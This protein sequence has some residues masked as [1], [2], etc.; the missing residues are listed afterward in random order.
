MRLAL[1]PVKRREESTV[2]RSIKV[3]AQADKATTGALPHVLFL[4]AALIVSGCVGMMAE[5][6]LEK[7]K[8]L[9]DM[10][11]FSQKPAVYLRTSTGPV[12]YFD[13]LKRVTE[14][15]G[16]FRSF[17]FDVA[18]KPQADYTIDIYGQWKQPEMGFFSF[19]MVVGCVTPYGVPVPISDSQVMLNALI[20]DR[21]GKRLGSYKI[22]ESVST[23]CGLSLLP[24][25]PLTITFEERLWEN[26]IKVLYKRILDDA[27]FEYSP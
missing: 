12:G 9:P 10:S 11:Q 26:M 18:D 24:L 7:V 16:L 1:R 8:S 17:S 3:H 19:V 2:N 6:K 25:A 22:E 20:E 21:H 5:G 15:S 27:L 23:W 13:A 14:Q 4:M